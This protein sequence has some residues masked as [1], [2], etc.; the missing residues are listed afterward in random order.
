MNRPL[1]AGDQHDPALPCVGEVGRRIEIPIVERYRDGAVAEPGGMV[2]EAAD[3]VRDAV[4]G[5]GVRVGVEL[6]L[7][8]GA[9]N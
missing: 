7:D 6:D 4:G 8:G 5:V 9:R 3:A 1:D 2:D